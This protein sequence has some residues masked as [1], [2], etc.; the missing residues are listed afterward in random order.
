MNELF[1]LCVEL[2]R[3]AASLVGMTYQ[4]INIW[5]FVVIQPGLIVLFAMLWLK[6]RQKA[7][8]ISAHKAELS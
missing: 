2:L 3:W 7:G 5:L 1:N 8:T 4:E 6:E